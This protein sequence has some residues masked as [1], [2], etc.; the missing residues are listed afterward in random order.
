MALLLAGCGD[1][2]QAPTAAPE[3]PAAVPV[4]SEEAPPA[5]PGETPQETPAEAAQTSQEAPATQEASVSAWGPA[6]AARQQ[7]LK[8]RLA[9][10]DLMNLVTCPPAQK[11]EDMQECNRKRAAAAEKEIQPAEG[12]IFVVV[13]FE[14]APAEVPIPFNSPETRLELEGGEKLAAHAVRVQGTKFEGDKRVPWPEQTHIE[15]E[16]WMS[17]YLPMAGEPPFTI[18]FQA[19]SSASRGTIVAKGVRLPLSW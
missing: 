7:Q 13:T 8:I 12:K 18:V 19:P 5:A 16:I 6:S 14:Q 4:A 10:R 1:K 9:T 17:T 2:P 11:M 3:P 15:L